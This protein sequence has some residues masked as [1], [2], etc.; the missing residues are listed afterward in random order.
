MK[1]TPI[2][3]TKS[4]LQNEDGRQDKTFEIGAK[5]MSI[6][7][8][9]DPINKMRAEPLEKTLKRVDST[10]IG[11]HH[12]GYGMEDIAL[13]F[14]DVSRIFCLYL[15]NLHIYDTEEQ[16]GRHTVLNLKP[17]EKPVFDYFY[18]KIYN[19]FLE[20]NPDADKSQLRQ[21]RQIALENA[22]YVTGIDSKTSMV[23]KTTLR[24][25]NYIY[26]WTGK[27]LNQ[28]DYNSY[29][30][31]LLPDM[32]D[33]Y[34]QLGSLEI[35]GQRIIEPRLKDPYNH[36]F[37]VFGDFKNKNEVY[38]PDF[39]KVY[40]DA[41]TVAFMQLHRH[42]QITFQLDNPDKQE[43]FKYYVPKIIKALNL[44]EDWASKLDTINNIPQ[45]RL[46]TVKETGTPTMVVDRL[47]E[48]AC[49][50]AQ[51][52]THYLSSLVADRVFKGL[53]QVDLPLSTRLCDMYLDKNRRSFPDYKCPPCK[54]PCTKADVITFGNSPSDRERRQ[55][56][57]DEVRPEAQKFMDEVHNVSA[58]SMATKMR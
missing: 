55:A 10:L 14:E 8:N 57:G 52:E 1:I 16:S 42:R 43:E 27:F 51:E 41:S 45:A 2:A 56:I 25:W 39:Y 44:E 23:Y 37:N 48:R 6:C 9:T 40:Y 28:K 26:D 12:S 58:E 46:L 36:D 17:N 34:E 29:E 31:A 53:A 3:I 33:F 38:D 4:L 24:Q 19:N 35:E 13:G 54:N 21:Y 5:V 32:R 50:Y 49:N 30:E 20:Q 18:D 15:H 7:V 22:R 47:K 11:R